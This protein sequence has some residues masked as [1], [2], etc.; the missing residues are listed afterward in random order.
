MTMLRI[1]DLLADAP[2][3]PEAH[4]DAQGWSATPG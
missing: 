3:D 4:L 2:V 1:D